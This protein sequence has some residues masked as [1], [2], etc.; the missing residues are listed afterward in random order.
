M[1]SGSPP[2]ASISR[3]A[4]S[5]SGLPSSLACTSAQAI[6]L[7]RCMFFS[8][9]AFSARSSFSRSCVFILEEPP[10]KCGRFVRD[11][12][13]LVRCLAIELEV[14]LGL[15]STIVPPGERFELG[16]PEAALREGGALDGDAD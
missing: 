1:T 5:A 15:G 3:S 13:D 16:A 2:V 7:C 10:Q 6:A 11:A 4:F 14:E 12:R 8:K 9:R